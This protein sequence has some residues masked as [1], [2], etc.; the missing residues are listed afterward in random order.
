MENI[1]LSWTALEFQEREK[2]NWW[3]AAFFIISAALIGYSVYLHETLT[4]ITFSVLAVAVFIFSHQ[5]PRQIQYSLTPVGVNMGRTQMPFRN[6]KKF[7]II[8]TDQNKTVNF[9][10]TS[11]LNSVLTLELGRQDPL[12]VKIFLKSYLP[13]DLQKEE[14][15]TEVISRKIKF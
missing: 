7:W 3:Y 15:F 8:Y 6:I 2:N 5:R 13:E 1:N 12:P 9:E 10:T 4:V 14:S 11:Y